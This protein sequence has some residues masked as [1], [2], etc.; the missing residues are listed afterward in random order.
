LLPILA[1]H[2]TRRRCGA[3]RHGRGSAF[4]LPLE[5]HRPYRQRID[6]MLATKPSQQRS[7]QPESSFFTPHVRVE[8]VAARDQLPAS[9]ELRLELVEE[10]EQIETV[11]RLGEHRA[12]LAGVH[13]QRGEQVWVPSRTY[14]AHSARPRR[15]CVR[16]RPRRRLGLDAA[17]LVQRDDQRPLGRIELEAA[18]LGR[19]SVDVGAEF[20]HHPL[21]PAGAA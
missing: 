21:L 9:R 2:L 20:A 11:A 15:P 4:S 7:R 12:H 10:T 14:R 3:A 5:H 17:L 8:V 18:Y 19:L 16:V 6:H 1:W 13:P